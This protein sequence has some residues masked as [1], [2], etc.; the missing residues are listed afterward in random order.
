MRKKRSPATYWSSYEDRYY[1]LVTIYLIYSFDLSQRR[2][3]K[4]CWTLYWGLL[5]IFIFVFPK[6]TCPG[7]HCRNSSLKFWSRT[8]LVIAMWVWNDA[9][10][11]LVVFWFMRVG[12]RPVTAVMAFLSLHLS[13]EHDVLHQALISPRTELTRYGSRNA[14]SSQLVVLLHTYRLS[15][16][17]SH[18]QV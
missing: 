12:L 11:F 3:N 5:F 10:N 9:I 15:Y 6:A 1:T 8:T 17:A 2:E 7:I 16:F 13:L 4:S 18:I 14:R